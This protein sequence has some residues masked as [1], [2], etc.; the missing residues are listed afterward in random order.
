MHRGAHCHEAVPVEEGHR[1]NLIMWCRSSDVRRRGKCAMCGRDKKP[2]EVGI[3]GEEGET[4]AAAGAG[5]GTAGGGGAVADGGAGSVAP[6][7]A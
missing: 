3:A 4:T 7:A 5:A 6:G 2:L 1:V